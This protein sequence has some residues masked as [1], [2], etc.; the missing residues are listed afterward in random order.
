MTFAS[1]SGQRVLVT[2]SSD[3]IG[4]AIA[5][6]C[7]KAGADLVVYSAHKFLGGPTAGI[8]GGKKDV[9]YPLSTGRN[10]ERAVFQYVF[11]LLF[12]LIP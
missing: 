6:E 3:G 8:V 11:S 9:K 1:L 4:R 7:A 2:G 12:H 10:T 5:L